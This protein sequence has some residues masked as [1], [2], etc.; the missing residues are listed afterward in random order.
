[1]PKILK[2]KSASKTIAGSS[3]TK[4][5]I[6]KSVSASMIDELFADVNPGKAKAKAKP[7]VKKA[8]PVKTKV[9]RK[10]RVVKAELTPAQERKA[11]KAILAKKEA[12]KEARAERAASKAK[13]KKPVARKTATKAKVVAR[14]PRAKKKVESVSAVKTKFTKA[15][16]I[17]HLAAKAETDKATAK[18]I[19]SE[20]TA[21][22]L[23]SIAPRGLGTFVLPGVLR[24][25]TRKVPARKGGKMVM[26]RFTGEM[27]KQ[28]AKAASIRV[29]IRPLTGLKQAAM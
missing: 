16:L 24:I 14:K 23:G 18:L 2:P 6:E 7:A 3:K 28:K 29:R 21:V 5:K 22:M 8:A 17:E 15:A 4:S 26:N 1:M 9:V 19:L 27:I 10:P 25:V 11:A 12:A 20:L 13:T